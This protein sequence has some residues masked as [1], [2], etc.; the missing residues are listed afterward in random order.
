ML[1][2]LTRDM[3][4]V[5]VKD[6]NTGKVLFE[7]DGFLSSVNYSKNMYNP[8]ITTEFSVKGIVKTEK[9]E[10]K[11]ECLHEWTTYQGLFDYHKVCTKCGVK[12]V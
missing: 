1:I 12:D 6:K 3:V 7:M 2:P 8:G 9:V 11:T 10:I 5:I 4:D